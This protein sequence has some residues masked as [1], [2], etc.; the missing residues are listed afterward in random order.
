[1]AVGCPDGIRAPRVIAE[2]IRGEI[3][4]DGLLIT[5]D[6]GM[7]ALQGTTTDLALQALDAGV[8]VALACSGEIAEARSLLA[9]VPELSA[10]ARRRL[11]AARRGVSAP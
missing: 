1:M 10:A 7:K 5:D 3:N 11:T 8:D 4:F 2:V 9:A 6:L